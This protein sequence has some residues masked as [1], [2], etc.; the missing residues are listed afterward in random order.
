MELR[1]VLQ[2]MFR[3]FFVIFTCSILA[4]SSFILLFVGDTVNIGDIIGVLVLSILTSSAYLIL[5]SKKELG[6]KQM[7]LRN[8][9][10]F[11]VVATIMLSGANF[12][13][14]ISP[15]EPAQFIFFLCLFIGIYTLV[16]ILE[17][18]QSRKLA[19][20]LNRKLQER[21]QEDEGAKEIK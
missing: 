17:L 9:I 4:M 11:V 2:G 18:H 5:Y 12:L 6:K 14:W 16:T 7:F 15:R 20:Q 1:E 19:N 21:Y 3:S 10:H 13:G 8:T